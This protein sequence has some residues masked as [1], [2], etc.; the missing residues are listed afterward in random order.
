MLCSKHRP[1]NQE[2]LVSGVATA[3]VRAARYNN[4]MPTT[5]VAKGHRFLCQSALSYVI[6]ISTTSK[7]VLL[8][9]FE[10]MSAVVHQERSALTPSRRIVR[11]LHW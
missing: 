1:D 2:L 9:D 10:R 11:A 3:E 6:V 8:T 7:V 4:I 5:I